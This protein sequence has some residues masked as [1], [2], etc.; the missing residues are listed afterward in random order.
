MM[1]VTAAHDDVMKRRDLVGDAVNHPAH[2]GKREKEAD[3]REKE[4][5]PRAVGDMLVQERS[6]PGAMEKHE[7]ER[8][9]DHQNQKQKRSIVEAHGTL[10]RAEDAEGKSRSQE[11]DRHEMMNEPCA[12]ENSGIEWQKPDLQNEGPALAQI[13]NVFSSSS[14]H[15]CLSITSHCRADHR[16]VCRERFAGTDP[17]SQV[18]FDWPFPRRTRGSGG[19]SAGRFDNI[20]F[21]RGQWRNLEDDRCGNGLGANL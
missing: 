13:Q 5:A 2:H 20:L 16:R 15:V 10:D 19:G 8:D 17:G 9:H 12:I 1:N 4:A 6:Q 18:A 21:W 3:G 11:M 14:L 7:Q